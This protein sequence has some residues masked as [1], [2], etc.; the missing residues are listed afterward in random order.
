MKIHYAPK[1]VMDLFLLNPQSVI[2]SM[3][4]REVRFIHK[5]PILAVERAYIPLPRAPIG[6]THSI[7]SKT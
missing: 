5:L 2:Y 3:P 7:A 6:R 1:A 4:A